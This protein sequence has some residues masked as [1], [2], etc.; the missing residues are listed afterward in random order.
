MYRRSF[1]LIE[2]L[3]AIAILESVPRPAL[4]RSREPDRRRVCRNKLRQIAVVSIIE[5]PQT[6]EA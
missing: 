5:K 6:E 2:Q 4:S 3:V 1:T